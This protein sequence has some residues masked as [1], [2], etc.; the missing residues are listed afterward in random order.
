MKKTIFLLVFI[1][2]LGGL[3]LAFIQP[4][5]SI[6]GVGSIKSNLADTVGQTNYNTAVGLPAIIGLVIKVFLG[7]LGVVFLGLTIYAGFLWMTASGDP[8]K[9]KKAKGIIQMAIIGL[10]IIIAAYAI[11]DFVVE[12]ISE[13]Q[14][15]S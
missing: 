8:E 11:T 13:M 9:V 5:Y 15:A 4:T 7:F 10:V 1:A 2:I 6:N 14:K 12:T 3:F